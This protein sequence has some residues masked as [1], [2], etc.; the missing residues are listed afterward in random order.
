MEQE[1]EPQADEFLG[2]PVTA[3]GKAQARRRRLAA[4]AKLTPERL[5]ELRAKVGMPPAT[6]AH[7]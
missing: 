7:G 2:I 5:S 1:R 6:A 4:Q 3:G